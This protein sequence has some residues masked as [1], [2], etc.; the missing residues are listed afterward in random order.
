MQAQAAGRPAIAFAG[1][2]ALDTVMD[3]VTGLLFRE[4]TGASLVETVRRFDDS[5]FNPTTIR[6]FA[7]RFDT[8]VFKQKLEAFIQDKVTR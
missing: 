3:S 8:Q 6:S 1:G 7:S 4:P 2:G 5:H